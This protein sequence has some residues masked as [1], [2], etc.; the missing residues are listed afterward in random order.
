VPEWRN[1]GIDAV[2]Y[3]WIWEKGH[4][5]KYFWCEASWILEDNH[6]MRN[7]LERMGF[8]IYKTYR[9]YERSV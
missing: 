6:A 7:G 4:A 8:A 3:K 2:L 1:R 5:R 9:I